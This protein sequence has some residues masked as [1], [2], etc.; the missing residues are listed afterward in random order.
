M[1]APITAET[2]ERLR[3]LG[4]PTAQ[5]PVPIEPHLAGAADGRIVLPYCVPC[6]SAHWYPALLC[7]TCASATWEWRDLGAEAVL[8]SW[9]VVH[10]PLAPALADH[11]PFTIALAVPVHAPNVR[12]VGVLVGGTDLQVGNRLRA[13]RGAELGTGRL[14]MF[15]PEEER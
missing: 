15:A 14:L 4:S 7:P 8:D 9:T 12:L 3:S 6:T 11:V 2:V 1:S 13:T 5:H 10:H